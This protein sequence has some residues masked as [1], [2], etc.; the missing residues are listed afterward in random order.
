MPSPPKDAKKRPKTK[1]PVFSIRVGTEAE[2]IIVDF[3]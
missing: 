2:P 1:P 3:K